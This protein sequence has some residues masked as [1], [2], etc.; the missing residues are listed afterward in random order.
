[1]DQRYW[2]R[3][4]EALNACVNR[5]CYPSRSGRTEYERK[6]EK[7]KKAGYPSSKDRFDEFVGER[8]GEKPSRLLD[9]G[10]KLTFKDQLCTEEFLL[11]RRLARAVASRAF[12]LTRA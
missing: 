9:R 8:R 4:E 12:R 2:P 3:I 7:E 11:A 1:M 5:P 6:R 10:P